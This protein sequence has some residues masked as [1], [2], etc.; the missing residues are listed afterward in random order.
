MEGE[1]SWTA[2]ALVLDILQ[3]ISYGLRSEPRL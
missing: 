2:R 3:G 1:I